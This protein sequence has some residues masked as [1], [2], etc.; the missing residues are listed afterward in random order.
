MIQLTNKGWQ[1][2]SSGRWSRR[3]DRVVDRKGGIVLDSR[4]RASSLGGSDKIIG[5]FRQGIGIQITGSLTMGLGD[6]VLFGSSRKGDGISNEGSIDMGLSDDIIIGSGK[7]EGI[8]NDGAILTGDGNDQVDASVGGLG[9]SGYIHLGS[10]NDTL[11]GFGSHEIIGG[12]GRDQALLLEGT[13]TIR[14][15]R[16]GFLITKKSTTME[17][18]QFE[19]IGSHLSGNT[20]GLK[21]G[22]LVVDSTGNL[23][24]I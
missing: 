16:G 17:L 15:D 9:G 4:T 5:F 2:S 11:R 12:T 19:R 8:R 1:G 23:N 3:A 14:A 20:L 13:Y 24:Y 22:T 10:G 18:Y 6:D 21:S 7:L